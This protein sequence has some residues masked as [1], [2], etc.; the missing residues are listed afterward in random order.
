[1]KSKKTTNTRTARQRP[2]RRIPS[3]THAPSAPANLRELIAERAY[4][5]YERRMRQGPL[6]DWLQAEQEILG[7]AT[8]QNAD[9]PHR[10]GYASEEQG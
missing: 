5:R 9:K 3:E 2:A 4:E 10:G 6:D 7:Q 8:I 1:M